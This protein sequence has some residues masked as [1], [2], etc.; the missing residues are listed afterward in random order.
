MSEWLNEVNMQAL[1]A[2]AVERIE[3]GR[4]S[5]GVLYTLSYPDQFNSTTTHNQ[6]WYKANN[7]QPVLQW[8]YFETPYK[9]YSIL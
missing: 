6:C 5:E 7:A 9:R 2:Q 3:I 1:Q 4:N 8:H